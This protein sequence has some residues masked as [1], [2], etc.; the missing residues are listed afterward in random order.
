MGRVAR[1]CKTKAEQ[2]TSLAEY[3]GKK[4]D[5]HIMFSLLAEEGKGIHSVSEANT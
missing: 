4:A 5:T 2:S 1:S 3:F